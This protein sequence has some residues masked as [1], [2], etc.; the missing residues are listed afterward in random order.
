MVELEKNSLNV[1][2]TELLISTSSRNVLSDEIEIKL[3][4]NRLHSSNSVKYLGVR[5]DKFLHNR[6][7]TISGKLNRANALIA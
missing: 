6:V 7:N 5:I 1:E 4:Q 3:C 2:N